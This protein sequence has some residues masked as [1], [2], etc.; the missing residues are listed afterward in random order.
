MRPALLRLATLAVCLAANMAYAQR[1]PAPAAPLSTR[2]VLPVWDGK[3][4]GVSNP[5]QHESTVA[6]PGQDLHIIRNVT[7]PTLLIR[8]GLSELVSPQSV[9][10]FRALCPD[11]EYV[12]V[13]GAAHM[14]AGDR[15]TAFNDALIDF[16]RRRVG[17]S[18]KY[19]S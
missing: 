7:V 18:N 12:D 3:V 14:V 15:N 2:P 10:E 5:A 17:E 8:G 16:L 11:A 1:P 13:P 19:R 6:V 9:A 4:P